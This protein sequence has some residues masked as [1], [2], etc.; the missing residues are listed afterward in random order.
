SMERHASAMLGDDTAEELKEKLAEILQEL[1]DKAEK[2]KMELSVVMMSAQASENYLSP[3]YSSPAAE[4]EIQART[5]LGKMYAD[6]MLMA[7]ANLVNLTA[8]VWNNAIDQRQLDVYA[9]E[10]KR[11][12]VNKLAKFCATF[13]KGL[14]AKFHATTSSVEAKAA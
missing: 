5:K 9:Q 7:D 10:V 11:D 12:C 2:T 4:H 1:K 6:V 8:L 14:N 3:N 13:L